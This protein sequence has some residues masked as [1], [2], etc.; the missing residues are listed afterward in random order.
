MGFLLLKAAMQSGTI[1]S[2]AQSPPPMT[3]PA[4]QLA[5]LTG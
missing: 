2:V 5:I 4:R 1:L 3:L